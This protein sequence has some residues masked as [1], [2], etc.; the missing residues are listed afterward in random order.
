VRVKMVLLHPCLFSLGGWAFAF[1]LLFGFG[2]FD[3][4]DGDDDDGN[5]YH[6]DDDDD[7]DDAD[8]NDDPT[9][10]SSRTNRLRVFTT[11][12]M[13]RILPRAT[14]HTNFVWKT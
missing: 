13:T 9:Y 3:Y 10:Y 11:Q 2:H 14:V 8:Q 5:D 7:D 12:A 1:A 6:D 4:Y